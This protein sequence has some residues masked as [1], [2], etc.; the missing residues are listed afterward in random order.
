[1]VVDPVLIIRMFPFCVVASD[2]LEDIIVRINIL[3]I[4]NKIK[5][6]I[7][8]FNKFVVQ[9]INLSL[10]L[11]NGQSVS[12]DGKTHII[13]SETHAVNLR[14]IVMITGAWVQGKDLLDNRQIDA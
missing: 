13:F 10:Y 8:I 4:Y 9:T 2:I 1:M 11:N 7:L 5:K 14:G 3:H 6:N 12:V